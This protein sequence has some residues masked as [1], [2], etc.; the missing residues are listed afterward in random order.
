[1]H[2]LRFNVSVPSEKYKKVLKERPEKFRKNFANCIW[3]ETELKE[4]AFRTNT[5]KRVSK[6]FTPCKKKVF[7]GKD[8]NKFKFC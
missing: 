5:T 6:P 8:I 2:H 3:T 1:M 4:R 7:K